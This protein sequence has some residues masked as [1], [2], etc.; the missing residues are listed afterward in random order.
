[1]RG[2]V[3]NTRKDKINQGVVTYIESKLGKTTRN[4]TETV[5]PN[6]VQNDKNT[7]LPQLKT[8]VR[9]K[10]QSPTVR[11]PVII[12]PP[13]INVQGMD[14]LFT[15]TVPLK[16]VQETPYYQIVKPFI[17]TPTYTEYSS[18]EM[19][20]YLNSQP[21]EPLNSII[22]LTIYQTW[23]TKDLPDVMQLCVDDIKQR[24]PEFQ[25]VLYDDDDCRNMIVANFEQDVVDA[26][27]SLIP[28]AYKADL[29]RYCVMYLYGGIYLD[30]KYRCM[31]SFKLIQLTDREY[32]VQDWMNNTDGFIGV[33]NA[34]LVCLP[35][36]EKMWDCIQQIV[37]NVRMQYYG[38]NALQP[39]G[40][41][42]LVQYFTK[43]EYDE[44]PLKHVEVVNVV[45][46]KKYFIERNYQKILFIAD[47]FRKEQSQT[48]RVNHYS[49]LWGNR[50]IYTPMNI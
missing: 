47:G 12:D 36:N 42:L 27:D 33:Y 43:E 23:H 28:G 30:I 29:W 21:V 50:A 16:M 46:Q 41:Q 7:D 6:I 25:H 14:A 34:L 45:G 2:L 9:L 15:N 1:M 40:P 13:V 31:G 37:K 24:N 19:S 4:I 22:P 10:I 48:Q 39:T 18:F 17:L 8:D 44:L 5:N 11:D 38:E 49:V 3:Q 20:M 26:F 32:F 35:G